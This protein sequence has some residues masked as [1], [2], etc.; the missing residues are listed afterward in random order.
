MSNY[1]VTGD[2]YCSGNDLKS[3]K[4]AP[5]KVGEHFSCSYNNLKS[6]EGAPEKV[7]GDFWCHTNDLKSLEGAPKEVSG[8]FYCSN[9]KNGHK[10]SKEDVRKVCNV[11]GKIYV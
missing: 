2:F 7:G 1:I 11:K 3:L 6:L 4:G 5:E 8:N 9:Q 10:F